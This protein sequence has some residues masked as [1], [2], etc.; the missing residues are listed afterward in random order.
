MCWCKQTL[1]VYLGELYLFFWSIYFLTYFKTRPHKQRELS[2]MC[3]CFGGLILCNKFCNIPEITPHTHTHTHTHT[4][5]HTHTYTRT[6]THNSTHVK[7][8][9]IACAYMGVW[10]WSWPHSARAVLLA[11]WTLSARFLA[12]RVIHCGRAVFVL[13]LAKSPWHMHTWPV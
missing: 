8:S 4:D 13:G 1:Y 11:A 5:T 10:L 12:G 7:R 9:S 2:R 6:N 3:L